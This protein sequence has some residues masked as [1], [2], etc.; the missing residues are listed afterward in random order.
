MQSEIQKVTNMKKNLLILSA[1]FVVLFF[2][3]KP[4]YACTHTIS[5]YDSYG[6]GWHSNNFVTVYVNGSAVLTD[7]TL[8]SG[9]GPADYTFDASEGD[10][11]QITYTPG[12]WAS[13]CYFDITDGGGTI[14]T[15]DYYPNTSGTY[16]GSG[17]CPSGCSHTIS[18]YDSYGDGW[19][20]NNFVTV[21]VN[22][23][24]VLT[25]ITLGSGSGPANYSFMADEG[26]AIQV[27][28][29]AGSWASECYYDITDGTGGYLVQDYYPNSSGTYNGSGH[30]N[31]SGCP[32][33]PSYSY[34]IFTPTSTWQTASHNFP[35]GEC[36]IYAFNM[37]AD[38]EYYFK[39]GCGDGATADFDTYLELYDGSC[40]TITTNDDGCESLRSS[41]TY[42]PSTSGTYY[43]KVRGFGGA[44][45]N[46]TL[47]YSR[48]LLPGENCSN[49]QDLA[50]LTSPYSATTLGYENDFSDCS[51]NNSVDRFFYIDVPD[52][53]T[54]EIWQSW[55][56]YDSRH[57]MRYGGACPGTTV[58]GCIDDS[59]YTPISWTNTTG[60]EQR[61]YW[62]NAGYSSY[63]GDFTLNWTL[64][65]PTYDYVSTWVSMDTGASD[66]CEGETRTVSVSVSNDGNMDW[67]DGGSN[68]FNIGVKWNG[69]PDYLVRVDAQDLAVGNTQTFDLDITAPSSPGSNNLT[70]DI[71]SEGCF[72]FADNNDGCGINT[73]GP[74]NTTYTS[75]NINIIATPTITST[76]S[77]ERCGNG[78]LSIEANSD[79]G[80]VNWYDVSSGGTSI[81]SG[82]V[83]TTPTISSS[84]TYYAEAISSGCSSARTA[85]NATIYTLPSWGTINPTD[86]DN[87]CVLDGVYLEAN[88]NDGDPSASLNW[89]RKINSGTVW[90]NGISNNAI[91]YPSA[92]TY[93]YE[94]VYTSTVD[95]CALTASSTI[96]VNVFED[97]NWIGDIS[98]DWHDMAN[99]CGSIPDNTS[100][101]S[102]SGSATN[103]PIISGNVANV[104]GL[105]IEHGASLE[106][107]ND[108]VLNI[109]C[110]FTNNGSFDGGTSNEEINIYGASTSFFSGNDIINHLNIIGGATLEINDDLN[111]RGNFTNNGTFNHNNHEISFVGNNPQNIT[112]GTSEFGDLTINNTASGNNDIV[113][114][115]NMIID[116][117]LVLSEG[118]INT[119]SFSITF[120]DLSN[121]EIG[122]ANSFIIGNITRSGSSPF[123]FPTGHVT[124]RDLDGDAV[125]EDYVIWAPLGIEP[126]TDA[127]VS[128]QYMFDNTGMPDWWE[129]S[130]NMDA[131]LHNVSSREYWIVDSDQDLTSVTLYWNDNAHTDGDICPHGFDDGI[132]AEFVPTDLSVAYWSGSMW[133]DVDYNSG[134]SV[135]DHDQGYITSRF[136]VPFGSKAP[137]YIT[138]GSKNGLN[139][140]PVDLIS[141]NANCLNGEIEFE[142]STATEI[143]ND[144]FVIEQSDDLSYFEP[145]LKIEGAGNANSINEYLE[146]FIPE[147]N[148]SYYRLVQ[149]DFDGKRTEYYPIALECNSNSLQEVELIAYP[150]P[151]TDYLNIELNN[152]N[153]ESFT[154]QILDELGR[155]IIEKTYNKNQTNHIYLNLNDLKPSMYYLRVISDNGILNKKIIKN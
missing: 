101:I 117:N 41:I 73:V 47:A 144:Y 18:L 79:F 7:I 44:G 61:V 50:S 82:S 155:I 56:N 84:T 133:T 57:T 1:I 96:T 42:T 27:A 111:I 115:D 88:V 103:Q 78:T 152:F 43:L 138:F 125:N 54:I 112:S 130:G 129:H 98:S 147:S 109:Y 100:N 65:V 30:C 29:T 95:G 89:R 135:L 114:L 5:L 62:I 134:S 104:C 20:G 140:L 38:V 105:T 2:T 90:T 91:D 33:C 75:G 32:T 49:A 39:T 45:G 141:F 107:T 110:S 6:D 31:V 131:S 48:D 14:I 128:V 80:T 68:D 53:A 51:M 77:S 24:A 69:D 87:Y 17:S 123:V 76:N 64:T 67:T 10:A 132:S 142:W 28:Y 83:F 23:S 81:G 154:I 71:V 22:G 137:R 59:D 35:T 116:D 40:S 60:S 118:I 150:N 97:G 136:S 13:E 119:N 9:S 126:S 74:S 122:N 15:D 58:I 36:R 139:P 85:V 127:T 3:T 55:N 143:N 19:H 63:S 124:S 106:L 34:G 8:S 151:V 25:N 146:Y 120:N 21:S 46:Y 72:W 92:E 102:I 99:W 16:N 153:D 26:D 52:G 149:V 121:S 11:I 148:K 66:W 86:G 94:P 70:F 4:T 145:I 37:E 93:D 113:L 108:Q 12:S